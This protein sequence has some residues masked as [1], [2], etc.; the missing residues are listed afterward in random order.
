M[1]PFGQILRRCLSPLRFG[2][3]LKVL[4]GFATMFMNYP[5]KKIA[6]LRA[7]RA[8]CHGLRFGREPDARWVL[9]L[10]LGWGIEP[11]DG[12]EIDSRLRRLP[13]RGE[14]AG[15]AARIKTV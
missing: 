12:G 14:G 15:G 10:H 2:C 8:G 5:G 1:A 13:R 3:S 4:S 9:G 6:D 11:R 7:T